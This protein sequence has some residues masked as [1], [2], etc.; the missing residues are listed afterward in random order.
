MIL[1]LP[2]QATISELNGDQ[3]EVGVRTMLLINEVMEELLDLQLL[4]KSMKQLQASFWRPMLEVLRSK[5]HRILEGL[6]MVMENQEGV[7]YNH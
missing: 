5:M 3:L 6:R 1:S 4:E 7:Y 2:H